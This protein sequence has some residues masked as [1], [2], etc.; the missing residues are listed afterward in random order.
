MFMLLNANLNFITSQY[1]TKTNNKLNDRSLINVTYCG[2]M[3]AKT[4]GV[5]HH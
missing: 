1:L 5:F 3:A 2:P 4:F